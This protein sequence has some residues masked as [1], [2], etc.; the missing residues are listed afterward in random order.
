MPRTTPGTLNRLVAATAPDLSEDDLQLLRAYLADRNA[1]AFAELIHRHGPMVF[2]VCLRVLGHA[3]DAEDA[4]Q[5]AFVVLARKA[6]SIRGANLAG[7]LYGVAVRTARGVRIM[8]DRRRKHEAHAVDPQ[9]KAHDYSVAEVRELASIVDEELDRLPEHYRL[10]IVLCE[11]QGRSR[12]EAAVELRV[13][14][15]TLSSRLATAKRKLAERLS[16]RGVTASAAA[17]SAT[18]AVQASALTPVSLLRV[19]TTA[20][21]P[22]AKAAAEGVV[23]SLLVS[24]LKS[25]LVA[26]GLA[27]VFLVGGAFGFGRGDLPLATAEEARVEPN[28]S[29]AAPPG[30]ADKTGPT[31]AGTRQWHLPRGN[32]AQT[33]TSEATLPESLSIQW[34][35]RARDAIEGSPCVADGVVFVGSYDKHVHAIDLVTGKLK[36]K[37]AIGTSKASA[38]FHDGRVYVGTDLGRFACLDA[39]TGEE[40]WSYA[41]EGEITASANFHAGRIIIPSH[42]GKIT[43]LDDRGRRV[44]QF[45]VTEPVHGSVAIV[46][47]LVYAVGCD[48]KLHTLDA[49]TGKELFQVDL[50][51]QTP[52]SPAVVGDLLFAG[53]MSSEVVAIDLKKRKRAWGYQSNQP[54]GFQGSAAV[55][56]DAVIAIDQNGMVLALDRA[57]G[58]LLWQYASQ[59]KNSGCSPVVVGNRVIIPAGKT[60]LSVLD[61]RT[62]KLM[63]KLD[64]FDEMIGSPAVVDGRVIVAT[65]RGEVHCL[66]GKSV[67]SRKP[68]PPKQPGLPANDDKVWLHFAKVVGDDAAARELFDRI[69]TNTQH[70]LLLEAAAAT[71]D[72]HHLYHRRR[73]TLNAAAEQ[74]DPRQL[75]L[76]RIVPR[77][78]DDVAGWLLLGTFP[79]TKVADPG[80]GTLQ[81]LDLDYSPKFL[82]DALGKTSPIEKPLRKLIAAWL[83]NRGDEYSALKAGLNLALRYEMEDSLPTA[84]RVLADYSDPKRTGEVK[85]YSSAN[86]RSLSL[87]LI[88][89]YGS[90]DDLPLVQKHLDDGVQVSA[91]IREKPGEFRPGYAVPIDGKDVTVTVGDVALAIAIQLRGGD[92][93]GFGFLW[94]TALDGAKVADPLTLG[95]IGFQS[96]KD[97]EAAHRKA[98]EWLKKDSN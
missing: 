48:G 43:A 5:A 71:S 10:A 47:D 73:D 29:V 59:E 65:M 3:Q 28:L 8:R 92:P 84:R 89:K 90:K 93:R 44:W 26:T 85:A 9:A 81:F 97:R 70:L 95:V 42:S 39:A 54:A 51:G 74:K 24:Q 60:T 30:G 1:D 12:R 82:T 34:T 94:P 86:L 4:F 18:F 11:L 23:K 40:I 14:E 80:G 87:L 50:E 52:S 31:K 38:A 16:R 20:C 6:G 15:G 19:A 62:G 91:V 96:I 68:D 27:C 55:A 7:W 57:T 78:L 32:P 35:Y 49:K 21:S 33:A 98:K 58:Q 22:L 61:L 25:V 77:P 53:T 67:A 2:A 13:P 63:E 69:M 72:V 17:I 79:G 66:G 46:G 37:T 88:G 41:T 36:W 45:K 64:L 83:A 56:G 75:G 76:S